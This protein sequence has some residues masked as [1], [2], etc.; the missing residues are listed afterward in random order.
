VYKNGSKSKFQQNY[1]GMPTP[2][3]VGIA[4]ETLEYLEACSLLFEQS[5]LSHNRVRD[6][7]SD[8]IKNINK[9][10]SYFSEWLDDILYIYCFLIMLFKTQVSP[11]FKYTKTIFVLTK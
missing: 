10:F 6:V 3:D 11:Y 8:V 2:V 7:N 4:S 9:G 1:T 5:F